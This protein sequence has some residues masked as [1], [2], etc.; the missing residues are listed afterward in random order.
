MFHGPPLSVIDR[1][2]VR[3]LLAVGQLHYQPV[4]VYLRQRSSVED[5]PPDIRL[6]LVSV[7]IDHVALAEIALSA[8][9]F[10]VFSKG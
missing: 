1:E 10:Q 3:V 6:P 7:Q 2:D 9:L 4:G 5:A 8:L